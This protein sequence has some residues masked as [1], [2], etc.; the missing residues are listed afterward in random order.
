MK[1]TL[2]ILALLLSSVLIAQNKQLFEQGNSLYNQGKYSEA[3]NKYGAI[4]DTKNHS[5]EL[6]YNLANAHYKLNHIA[7]SIYYYEKALLLNPDDADIQNNILFAR[8]MTIDAIDAIPNAGFSEF[9]KNIAN[10]FS[11]D[12]WAI[13]AIVLVFCFVILFVI[14]YFSYSTLIKR[15][16]FISSLL[17]LLVFV[18]SLIFAFHKFNIEKANKPAIVF[19]QETI[20]KSDPNLKSD[21]VFRLHEGT[22]V[23]VLEDYD[24]WQK[25]K[26]IDGKTGWV[27]S[28]DI[29]RVKKF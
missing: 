1:K 21:E 17:I 8:N 7:A 25:I 20:V 28:E 13:G 19:A 24:N 10:R 5:A 15:L 18:F 23:Q 12:T 16:T 4:L 26:L 9:I 29:K 3:I 27:I 14:Y 22:K 6:Y 11:F 2:Y